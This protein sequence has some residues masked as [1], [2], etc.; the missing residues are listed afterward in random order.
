MDTLLVNDRLCVY[1]VYICLLFV[2]VNA[3]LYMY[4][5]SRKKNNCCLMPSS[6]IC[7]HQIKSY[8]K[9]KQLQNICRWP[10][11]LSNGS[12]K[13]Y[14]ENNRPGAAGAVGVSRLIQLIFRY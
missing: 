9:K 12:R 14:C 6:N 11:H 4:Y 2:F 7:T 1:C 10:I 8:N 13:N 3:F 5:L